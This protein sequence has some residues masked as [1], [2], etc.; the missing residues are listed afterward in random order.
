MT[1]G[2]RGLR[3]LIRESVAC[4]T[5]DGGCG[6]GTGELCTVYR[7]TYQGAASGEPIREVHV[8]RWRAWLRTRSP[9]GIPDGVPE[10]VLRRF[11]RQ[12][13]PGAGPASRIVVAEGSGDWD[14][15][16]LT[17]R[18]SWHGIS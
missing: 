15:G 2:R 5:S 7:D 13:R 3:T 6:A 11:T 18:V 16:P 9:E 4:D 10:S 17:P 14:Y 1:D 12:R 8:A